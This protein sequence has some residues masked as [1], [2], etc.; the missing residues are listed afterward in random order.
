MT[1]AAEARPVTAPEPPKTRLA[2]EHIAGRIADGSYTPG[3]RLVLGRIARELDVSTVP[4][5]EAMR[6]LEAEGA[7][8][9]EPNVGA[10]VA[11]LDPSLYAVTME[12]LALVEG[13][14]TA[15]AAA[16]ISPAT[17]AEAREINRRMADAVRDFDPARAAELNEEFHRTLVSGCENDHITELAARGWARLRAL[18][19]PQGGF[20][21][22]R[23]A[24]AIAEHDELL[25][26]IESGAPTDEIERCARAHRLETLASFKARGAIPA[27][28]ATSH[29]PA[30]N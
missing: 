16:S 4:V 9:Y 10:Q 30:A 17:I 25:G 21:P 28:A 7:I 14:A 27:S 19:G 24:D 29:G 15:S 22:G 13:Y 11:T 23:A 18:R 26:L 3:S 12:T 20:V 1:S 8:T 5:R 2:Y 6:M